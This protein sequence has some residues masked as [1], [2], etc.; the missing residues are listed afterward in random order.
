MNIKYRE[1]Y[2]IMDME[3]GSLFAQLELFVTSS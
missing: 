2:E 1:H 3:Q